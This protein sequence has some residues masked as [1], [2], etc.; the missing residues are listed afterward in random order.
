MAFFGGSF[1]IAKPTLRDPNFYQTVVLLVQHD[2]EGAF[3]LVVNRPLPAPKD[4]ELPF[5]LFAGGPC[6]AE[7]LFMVHGHEEWIGEESEE[8]ANAIAPGIFL[9]D[10]SLAAKLKSLSKSALKRVRLFHGYAGW[11]PG[12][13][14]RELA[15]GAWSVITADAKTLFKTR[16]NDLWSHLR[17]PSIPQPSLN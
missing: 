2:A 3:G 4:Q 14:E 12:Q 9:G 1:L 7:G 17:P 6:E 5:P 11:G 15:E 16:P 8:P 10:A 13:L